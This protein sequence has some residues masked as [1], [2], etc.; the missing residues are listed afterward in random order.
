MVKYRLGFTISGETLFGLL[1][2]VLPIEDLSVE[3]IAPT[4]VKSPKVAQPLPKLVISAK[5]SN[6]QRAP[7]TS[8]GPNLEAGVNKVIMDALAKGPLRAGELKG[9][10]EAAGYAATGI[11][12]RLERLLHHKVL[13]RPQ[14]GLYEVPFQER[15]KA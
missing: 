12:S 2:R 15:Q 13:H 14:P 8:G 1:A 11:G 10:V 3:E 5:K 6:K 9:H 4:P 7:R